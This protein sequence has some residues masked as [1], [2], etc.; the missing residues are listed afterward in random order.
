MSIQY[1]GCNF[2]YFNAI[3][4]EY[5]YLEVKNLIKNIIYKCYIFPSDI[6]L[7]SKEIISLRHISNIIDIIVCEKCQPIIVYCTDSYLEL[8]FSCDIKVISSLTKLGD[9]P[10]KYFHF[11]LKLRNSNHE[12]NNLTI[13]K[14]K[15]Q[16]NIYQEC[17]KQLSKTLNIILTKKNIDNYLHFLN[18]NSNDFQ[19]LN[20]YI[21]HSLNFKKFLQITQFTNIKIL[22]IIKSQNITSLYSIQNLK[23][24]NSLTL[25]DCIG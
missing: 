2:I 19:N 6:N 24:I 10:N 12:S 22:S 15:S 14:L 7:L 1:L 4:D 21:K 25:K 11:K 16:N 8:K 23:H 20:I 18:N 13:Y 9:Y 3:N 5:F 17:L